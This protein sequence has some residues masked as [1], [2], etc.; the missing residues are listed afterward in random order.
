MTQAKF[1]KGSLLKHVM[2]VSLTSSF[3]SMILH[4]VGFV[5][6]IFISM[7]GNASLAAAAGYGGVVMFAAVAI[8]VGISTAAGTLA[9]RS[10]GAS[11]LADARRQVMSVLTIGVGLS[12][13][14]VIAVLFNLDWI[15]KA[16]GAEGETA[17]LTKTFLMVLFPVMPILMFGMICGTILRAHGDA[18]QPMISIAIGGLVNAVLDPILIFGFG[19]GL[20]GAA[21]ASVAAYVVIMVAQ[22]APLILKYDGIAKFNLSSVRRDFMIVCKLA[23][24]AIMANLA[25]PIG[26]VLIT[27]ELARFGT[28]AVAGFA[29]IRRIVPIAFSVVF[30]VSGAVGPIIGQNFGA[31]HKD[32]MFETLFASLKFVTAYIMVAAT[33]LFI[34]R[35][36]IIQIFGIKGDGLSLVLLFCGPLAFAFTFE[37]WLFVSNAAFNTLGRPIYSMWLNW[38]RHTIGTWPFI[39][40]GA[41]FWGVNG[42]LIGPA[43]GGALFAVVGVL[44]ANRVIHNSLL[45]ESAK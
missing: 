36:P 22:V 1:T 12:C 21:F 38:G 19:L 9:A 44:L 2:V 11:R 17:A 23:A 32:R 41:H 5:D 34:L 33:M 27:R 31:G 25:T 35:F 16:L 7:L 18:K 37:A 10:I 43:F 39:L 26:N 6:L 40:M 42:V 13:I 3:G 29:I 30:T 4:T 24:P 14:I 20:K 28:D 8:S 15:I 45:G